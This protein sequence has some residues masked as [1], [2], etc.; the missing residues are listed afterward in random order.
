MSFLPIQPPRPGTDPQVWFNQ[1][2][3]RLNSLINSLVGPPGPEGPAGPAGEPGPAGPAGSDTNLLVHELDTS[4]HGVGLIVGATETQTLS[5]K[6]ILIP[7][8]TTAVGL[9]LS[10]QTIL[11]VTAACTIVVP[12]AVGVTGR[13]YVIDSAHTGTTTVS[14]TGGETIE[15]ETT[16]T[17]VGGGAMTLYSDGSNWRIT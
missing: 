17:M 2:C 6:T 1:V 8:A 7:V 14:P 9:T 13:V 4:T 16:Q 3:E 11:K 10:S 15:G 12:T 5:G